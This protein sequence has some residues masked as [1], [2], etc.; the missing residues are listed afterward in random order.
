MSRVLSWVDVRSFFII[1]I[2][3]YFWSVCHFLASSVILNDLPIFRDRKVD[4]AQFHLSLFFFFDHSQFVPLYGELDAI[5]A[6][7]VDISNDPDVLNICCHNFLESLYCQLLL[8]FP[9]T[10]WFDRMF[11][12][13]DQGELLVIIVLFCEVEGRQIVA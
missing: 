8:I 13:V 4:I 3:C 2:N 11:V 9:F 12:C 5:T 10:R 6:S 7:W 1:A